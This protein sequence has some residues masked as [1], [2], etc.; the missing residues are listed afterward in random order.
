MRL[1]AA[2]LRSGESVNGRTV[3]ASSGP[4]QGLVLPIDVARSAGGMVIMAGTLIVVTR[5][6]LLW[7]NRRP[8]ILSCF[9]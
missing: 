4:G 7:R 3:P 2:L 9:A 1:C 5:L 8:R 6:F